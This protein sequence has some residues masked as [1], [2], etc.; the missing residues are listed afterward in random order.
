M[1]KIRFIILILLFIPLTGCIDTSV[2]PLPHV[3]E[4]TPSTSDFSIS[5]E[6]ITTLNPTSA[7]QIA[8]SIRAVTPKGSKLEDRATLYFSVEHFDTQIF[9]F[10][11]EYQ[12]RWYVDDFMY[13]VQGSRT[14]SYL[15]QPTISLVLDLNF[16]ELT[17][18]S[19]MIVHFSNKDNTWS[20]TFN[21][22][23]MIL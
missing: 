14:M 2:Q 19:N 20:K 11:G 8:F 17:E 13:Y 12:I 22:T 4:I 1:K 23:I 21:I 10:N 7:P 16:A 18:T 15:E 9:K 3:F 5:G 6:N